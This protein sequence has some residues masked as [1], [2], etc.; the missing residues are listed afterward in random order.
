MTC[1]LYFRRDLV[2]DKWLCLTVRERLIKRAECDWVESDTPSIHLSFL[3]LI[4][5]Q[6]CSKQKGLCAKVWCEGLLLLMSFHIV[7]LHHGHAGNVVIWHLLS[8]FGWNK[9]SKLRYAT[10]RKNE[11]EPVWWMNR[12]KECLRGPF[13]HFISRGYNTTGEIPTVASPSGHKIQNVELSSRPSL[14]IF[15]ERHKSC[16]TGFVVWLALVN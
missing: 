13:R 7:S 8:Q 14:P 5:N 9:V 2:W 6:D 12:V 4:L 10:A 11:P 1:S 3:P 15:G 16:W